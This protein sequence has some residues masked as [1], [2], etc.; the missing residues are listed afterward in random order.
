M[1][2]RHTTPPAWEA[3]VGTRKPN[4]CNLLPWPTGVLPMIHLL[5]LLRL[6]SLQ[7]LR[8]LLVP[9]FHGFCLGLTGV[10]LLHFLVL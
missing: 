1:D 3:M 2:E 9:T 5:H 8:L 6:S 4:D 7:F 10:A